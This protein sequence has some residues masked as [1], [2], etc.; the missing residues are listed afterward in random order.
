MSA[1]GVPVIEGYHGTDQSDATLEKEA[2]KIGFPVMI[3][4]V[5]GGGGKVFL[6][7]RFIFNT[8]SA[9]ERCHVLGVVH[10]FIANFLLSVTVKEI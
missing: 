10:C 5:R 4:A 2:Q 9:I 7:S 1:A 6:K 3:K 8:F